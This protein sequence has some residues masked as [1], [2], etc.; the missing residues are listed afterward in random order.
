MEQPTSAAPRAYRQ[1][2]LSPDGRR[3]AVAIEEQET[4]VWLYDLARD[5]LTRFSFQGQ[6]SINYNPAW[7]PDGKR[8]L[9][10]SPGSG[11][12]AG[13]FW[14]LAD[15]SG[16]LER[17]PG[18]FGNPNSWTPDGQLVAGTSTPNSVTGSGFDIVLL[19]LGDPENK[20]FL[21]TTFNEGSPSF[22]PDGRWLAYASDESGRY[23]IYVNAY[24]GPGGKYQISTE[25]GIEPVWNRNGREL[26]YRSGDRMMAVDITT[27][28]AFS[29]GTPKVLFQGQ[30]E[31]NPTMNPNYDV[32]A[33]GQ[34]FLML[35][36]TSAQ[37]AAP[38]QINVVLNWFEELKQ[39][40]PPGN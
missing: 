10:Q 26:F 4:R 7:T 23:E 15:G 36:P 28:P 6:G 31:R 1:P 24:P 2:R 37:E 39:R 14:Q 33:D 17:L 3:V 22:S 38:T 30:Y 25:G 35:K 5:T 21:P 40:V 8:I 19:R 29:A 13:S 9:F 32:S 18:G 11:P 12:D 16:G 27:Q 34:R 20:R